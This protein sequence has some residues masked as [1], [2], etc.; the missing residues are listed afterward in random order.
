[1]KKLLFTII[2]CV[3]M[4]VLSAQSLEIEN[5]PIKKIDL[6]NVKLTDNFWLIKIRQI[7]QVTIPVAFERCEAE[8]RFENFITAEKVING[9]TGAVRGMMPFDDTDVYKIIEGASLSLVSAPDA[10]LETQL[11]RYIAIVARGQEADG[12]LTTWRTINP[13][14][15][16]AAWVGKCS[17]RWDNLAMSHELYNAGH[18]Y[19][20]AAAHFY[21]TGKRNFLEIALKNA[22]L[23]V[24]V[25]AA[26]DNYEIPG[27]QIIE[28]GLIKLYLI[29]GKKDYLNLAKKFL[30][31]RGTDE[32]RT[33]RGEYSQDHKPVTEQDEVVGHAVRA[34][35]MYAG[36]T[37][38]A[39][40]SGDAGY[41]NAVQ[42][43]W[44]NMVNRKMY[45]SGGLGALHAGEAFGAN[46]ELPNLTA[47]NETCAAIGG[48]MWADRMFRLFGDANYYNI[49][50]RMLYNGV[51]SGISLDGTCFFYPN[52]LES[53]G[54]YK[55]NQ[56]HLTRAGWFDCSCC[57]T[58]F[59]RFLPSLPN[60]I[61]N[62]DNQS[63][64]VNLFIANEAKIPFGKTNIRI[65]QT[66]HYP[67]DANINI[68]VN[69][70]KKTNFTLKIRVPDWATNNFPSELYSY[71]NTVSKPI[72]L[73][74][75]GKQIEV[76]V[77]NA[78]IQISRKWAKGDKIDIEFPLQVRKIVSNPLVE[79][80][81]GKIALSYGAFIYCMESADNENLWDTV[82]N[83]KQ[84]H[85]TEINFNKNKLAGINE[86]T[87][88]DG[89]L[90]RHFIPYYAWSNRG[91]GQMKVWMID[92]D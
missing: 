34:V 26:P 89:S 72:K 30:D 66:T 67:L 25:F 39:A 65:T 53:D 70:D 87:L 92:N 36:M 48:V 84:S 4:S 59:I 46:Y 60:L 52:P 20:A 12:Y 22:D 86:I 40:I 63:V 28:T 11:D 23:M 31:L 6:R 90:T 82:F 73:F 83:F 68:A 85:K 51:L 17:R 41:K 91:A 9:G 75:N 37:D 47:Y 7:Q 14:V 42:S 77:N 18:L 88:N 32:N 35:Y 81:R 69:P 44:N 29:T 80:N 57:P 78:Y 62:V 58:N 33:K 2:Y 54:L 43:L 38:I 56:G 13:A 49:L 71:Q 79:D 1:M 76:D 45:V 24:K 61:Y 50:E 64:Y 74:L 3:L 5:Y 15:P 55:F 19:E 16:P 21:A 27:H 10:K 8:G